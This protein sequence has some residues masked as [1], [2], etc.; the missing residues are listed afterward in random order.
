MFVV[1][2]SLVWKKEGPTLA[3][4]S[5]ARSLQ[6]IFPAYAASCNELLYPE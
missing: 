2:A 1:T 3:R 6:D 5:N 4:T